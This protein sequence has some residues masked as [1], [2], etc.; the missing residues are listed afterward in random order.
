MQRVQE[1][2]NL[3]QVTLDIAQDLLSRSLFSRLILWSAEIG[4]HHDSIDISLRWSENQTTKEHLLKACHRFK[5]VS[6]AC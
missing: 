6:V 5:D 2:G 1:M 4:K 3:Y